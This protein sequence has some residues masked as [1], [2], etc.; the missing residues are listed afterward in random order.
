[1]GGA[2]LAV[3]FPRRAGRRKLAASPTVSSSIA[4]RIPPC[5]V[6]TG[7]R[8]SARASNSTRIVSFSGSIASIPSRSSAGLTGAILI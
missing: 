6:P 4:V 3:Q 1:M 2:A 5:T 8:N 7:L